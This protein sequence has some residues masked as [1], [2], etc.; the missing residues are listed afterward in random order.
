MAVNFK[1]LL[2]TPVTSAEKPKPKPAG[3]YFGTIGSFRYGES[4]E[5][6]TPYVKLV[7]KSVHPGPGI[8]NDSALMERLDKAGDLSKFSPDKDYYLTEDAKYRLRE[9]MESCKLRVDGRSFFECIPELVN[10]P[11]AF[12]LT[13]ESYEARDGT[14]GIANRIGQMRGA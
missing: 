14:T 2:S 6:K 12:D 7:V 11:V 3:Q 9:L 1:E 10:Q 4:K 8:T 13:E 5:Q